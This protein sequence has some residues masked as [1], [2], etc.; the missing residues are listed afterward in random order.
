MTSS[1]SN[2]SWLLP[3][4]T[5]V[6][7]LSA[8]AALALFHPSLTNPQEPASSNE[9]ALLELSGATMGTRYRILLPTRLV[10]AASRDSLK[11]VI[12]DRLAYLDRQ[13]MSTYTPDS[14]LSQLNRQPAGE[15]M[16]VA[17][18]LMT[19]LTAA[20]KVYQQSQGAFD[21][22]VK[23]L[24]DL[25]GF[26]PAG[27]RQDIPAEPDIRQALGELGMD[28]LEM[29]ATNSTV[30][31]SAGIT[32][33]LSAIAKGYAV[34]TLAG[35][36]Q[37]RGLNDFLV[38]I[39]GEVKIHGTRPDGESWQVGIE[40]P[41]PGQS[42]LFQSLNTNAAE[43]AIAASGNY[44]NYFMHEGK[45]YSHT[46]DP[47]SGWPV[48]HDLASVTVIAGSAMDADAWATALSVLGVEAGMKLANELQ[49]AAY[50][51][52]DGASGY[53]ALHTDAFNRYL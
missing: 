35:L 36:L 18:E 41:V 45:R 46:I 47:R 37:A 31:R 15:P 12:T 4:L 28:R 9:N 27:T 3:L 29:D 51:I 19:V 26:G 23:P 13:L 25:W 48:S 53:S 7:L 2:Q 10:E 5:L 39:G 8:L 43:L 11:T 1:G 34:D 22:T 32:L 24:V 21:I 6:V 14:Q 49:L 44:R 38:E 40:S 17:T 42:R 33:D 16:L 50:F 20:K 30:M 52:V